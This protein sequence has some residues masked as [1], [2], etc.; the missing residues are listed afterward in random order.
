MPTTISTEVEV[1]EITFAVPAQTFGITCAISTEQTLPVVTEFALRLI[2]VCDALTAQDLQEFF[3]FS[4]R[5]VEQVIQ[6][7]VDERLLRWEEDRLE[8]THYAR[9]LFVSSPDSVPRLTK[10][11]D[12]AGE[13]AFELVGFTPVNPTDGAKR[14]RLMV[15]VPADDPNKESKSRLWAERSFQENFDRIYRGSR[16]EIYKISD[17]EASTR[18]LLSV[19]C[20]FSVSLDDELTIKR[21]LPEDYLSERLEL[22]QAITAVLAYPPSPDNMFLGEFAQLFGN[23]AVGAFLDSNGTFNLRAF[24]AQAVTAT[25][26]ASTIVPIIGSLHLD[27]NRKLLETWVGGLSRDPASHITFYWVAPNVP[28]WARSKRMRPLVASLRKRIGAPSENP[29]TQEVTADDVSGSSS[30]KILLQ[31]FQDADRHLTKTYGHTLPEVFGTS[32]S[33]LGGKLELLLVPEQF[34]CALYHYQVRHAVSI[35]IG[36]MSSEEKDIRTAEEVL[37]RLTQAPAKLS[38]LT[39]GAPAADTVFRA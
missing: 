30:V 19:P 23:S 33:V 32:A 31:G 7:L 15:E 26:E 25:S 5:E 37:K 14:A 28:F 6:S 12:W 21:S 38:T 36:L 29:E 18:F 1:T 35:P 27:K 10:I 4:E 3:G 20:I 11:K 34:M 16:A 22:S 9:G 17:V 8:L 39:K 13:V 2:S 24:L